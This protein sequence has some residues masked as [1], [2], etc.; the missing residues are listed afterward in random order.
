MRDTLDGEGF[1][2]QMT[3]FGSHMDVPLRSSQG[4]RVLRRAFS[5]PEARIS[6]VIDPLACLQGVAEE[7]VNM[8][9]RSQGLVESFESWQELGHHRGLLTREEFAFRQKALSRG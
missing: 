1:A 7:K 8:A 3:C 2:L 5:K 9:S 4:L 6:F